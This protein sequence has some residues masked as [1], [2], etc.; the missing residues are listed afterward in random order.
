MMDAR[1]WLMIAVVGLAPCVTVAD[2]NSAESKAIAKLE[3]LGG[4]V[5][6]DD[7]LLGRP[8]IGVNVTDE[9]LKELKELKNLNQLFVDS[10]LITNAG[11][12]ELQELEKLT[13][14]FAK[15]T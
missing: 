6:R 5:T 13:H 8:V 2:D 11:L 7:S 14:L 1:I 3:L 12:M 4:N 10:S 9:G 15:T